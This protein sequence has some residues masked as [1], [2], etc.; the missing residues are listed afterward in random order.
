MGTFGYSWWEGDLSY[1]DEIEICGSYKKISIFKLLVCGEYGR[2]NCV[3]YI[4]R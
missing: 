3:V 2:K 4:L 1:I